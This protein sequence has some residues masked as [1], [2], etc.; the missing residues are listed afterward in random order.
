MPKNQKLGRLGYAGIIVQVPEGVLL[1]SG[2]AILT[3]RRLL[4]AAEECIKQIT[5]DAQED[6]V[7]PG[8]VPDFVGMALC[9]ILVADM[10]NKGK[11]GSDDFRQAMVVL[12]LAVHSDAN[13]IVVE[14]RINEDSTITVLNFFVVPAIGF[15]HGRKKILRY[16]DALNDL[17]ATP[18]QEE[19][20]GPNGIVLH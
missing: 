18:D 7:A 4:K 12:A 19:A 15:D 1:T 8:D 9:E 3:N 10:Q 20:T 11:D 17:L 14:R 13:H 16:I 6:G 5:L 2:Q